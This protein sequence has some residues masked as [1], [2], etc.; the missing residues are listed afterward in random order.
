MNTNDDVKYTSLQQFMKDTG[1]LSWGLQ[2]I[3]EVYAFAL[4]IP[5]RI[6]QHKEAELFWDKAIESSLNFKRR[7]SSIADFNQFAIDI[8]Q[9]PVNGFIKLAGDEKIWQP[10]LDREKETW[11]IT[12][13]SNYHPLCQ[14]FSEHRYWRWWEFFYFY[15]HI[16]LN[17]PQSTVPYPNRKIDALHFSFQPISGS[18]NLIFLAGPVWKPALRATGEYFEREHV[19]PVIDKFI[20]GLSHIPDNANFHGSLYEKGQFV[21]RG[22]SRY[23]ISSSDLI[24]RLQQ[25]ISAI[26]CILNMQVPAKSELR[27]CD[28]VGLAEWSIFTISEL[29]RIQYSPIYHSLRDQKAED[30]TLSIYYRLDHSLRPGQPTIQEGSS[31]I[32]TSLPINS[33]TRNV[34][35]QLHH[36]NPDN[37]PNTSYSSRLFLPTTIASTQEKKDLLNNLECALS[38]FLSRIS[39]K[40]HHGKTEV[41]LA[42][43]AWLNDHF[44]ILT[45]IGQEATKTVRQVSDRLCRLVSRSLIADV[46]TLYRYDYGSL[47]LVTQGW[48]YAGVKDSDWE[49]AMCKSMKEAAQD[50]SERKLSISYRAVDQAETQFTCCFDKTQYI[51]KDSTTLNNQLLPLPENIKSALSAIAVPVSVYGRPWGVLE[52]LGFRPYQFRWDNCS[53]MEEFADILSPFFYHQWFL[54]KLDSLNSITSNNSNDLIERYNIICENLAGLFLSYGASLWVLNPVGKGFFSCIGCYNHP[55]LLY[56]IKNSLEPPTYKVS[57]KNSIVGQVLRKIQSPSKQAQNIVWYHGLVGDDFLNT[58]C[59]DP[60]NQELINAGIRSI[61]IIPI[62]NYEENEETKKV[63]AIIFLYNKTTDEFNYRWR[64]LVTFVTRYTALLLGAIHAQHDWERRARSFIAHEMKT[65]IDSVQDRTKSLMD[66]L[67]KATG[68]L[69]DQK[70]RRSQ[71]LMGDLKTY[72]NDLMHI[73][74]LL[75]EPDFGKVLLQGI[76]PMFYIARKEINKGHQEWLSLR[77]QINITFLSHQNLIREKNLRWTPPSASEIYGPYLFMS[78]RNL[79]EILDNICSNAIKYAISGSEIRLSITETEYTTRLSISNIGICLEEEEE[80]RLFREG[81]RGSNSQGISGEGKGLFI[82][83]GI[84]EL[85]KIGIRYISQPSDKPHQD[86]CRHIFILSFPNRLR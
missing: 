52:V 50:L 17:D 49:K 45:S 84:C 44:G 67:D 22:T 75:A 55:G 3:Q 86:Y 35:L 72:T 48:F 66:L 47:E 32:T 59:Q 83:R 79:R 68:W 30:G 38:R 63:T 77:K 56:A 20:N 28:Y 11:W 4:D 7:F 65:Q 70:K 85:Y 2:V 14:M 57:D 18:N 36:T 53:I 29:E 78:A 25:S 60:N 21:L 26:N 16:V 61:N 33:S 64:H 58:W 6:F 51:N 9:D 1:N 34:I 80:E 46:A 74:S 39:T 54:T 24:E 15:S 76:D 37:Y 12:Q 19:K 5:L 69:D 8:S 41:Q 27:R 73:I 81:F 23:P 71:I 82:A 43:R 62:T 10:L 42:L 13:Q 40:K 31:W